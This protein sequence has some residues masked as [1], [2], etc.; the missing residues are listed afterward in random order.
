MVVSGSK[1]QEGIEKYS[2]FDFKH[3]KIEVRRD[4]QMELIY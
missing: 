2:E 1:W 3:A 4:L